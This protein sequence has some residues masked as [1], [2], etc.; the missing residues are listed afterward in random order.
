MINEYMTSDHKFSI[1]LLQKLFNIFISHLAK[2]IAILVS[3]SIAILDLTRWQN[4]DIECGFAEGLGHHFLRGNQPSRR[5]LCRIPTR[6]SL[7]EFSDCRMPC[8]RT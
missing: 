4:P 2:I 1:D 6:C 8:S 3:S 5:E 7:Y